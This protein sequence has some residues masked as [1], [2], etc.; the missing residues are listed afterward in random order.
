MGGVSSRPR[1]LVVSRGDRMQD[2]RMSISEDGGG[3]TRTR[4]GESRRRVELF[5]YLHVTVTCD[6][7]L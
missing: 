2:P 1:Y 3:T 5:D 7:L 4:R 6:G